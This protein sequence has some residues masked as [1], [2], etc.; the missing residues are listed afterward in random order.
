M[1]MPIEDLLK[2]VNASL[3]KASASFDKKADEAIKE[4]KAAGGLSADTKA[5][6]DKM[7]T[8]VNSLRQAQNALQVQ[9]GEAEQA[10]A[11]L[12][13]AGGSQSAVK[14]AGQEVAAYEP[15]KAFAQNIEG[16]RRLSVPV[17]RAALIS[18][19]V[20]E[21]IVAPQRLPGIDARPK[22]RLF[23]RDLIAP[24]RTTAPAIF[25]V[26]MTGF[27]NNARVVAEGTKKP[28]SNIAFDSKI[29]G[30]STIAHLFKASKQILADFAQ[31]QSTI[32]AELRF[33]L[34]YVEEQEILFGDGTGVH[35]H[36]IVPQASAFDPAFDVDKQTGIDDL[37][38][39]ML[40]AQLARV[41]ATGHVLHFIDW[42]KIELTKDTLGRY[43][44][45]NPLGLAGPVLWGLPVVATEIAAFQGKFLTGSFAYGAQLFDREDANVVISTENADDFENNM[46]T[47]RCEER[48]ALAV[49]RPEAFIYGSFT[50]PAAG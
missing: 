14:S 30:V 3:D 27:T 49:K 22:Q 2:Q 23:I 36:G 40:Q 50:P 38:L 13:G 45:A 48:A 46:I 9:L 37:R 44:L 6:V 42:A 20:A 12:P 17:P 21:G 39:A 32:D 35:L 24:G 26:Q 19:D 41:P 31:L 43:V 16:G 34:K 29:T 18:T 8:E 28:Y 7:A 33:G 11:A 4:A 25:W 1:S 47:I 15:L 10:F 5:A